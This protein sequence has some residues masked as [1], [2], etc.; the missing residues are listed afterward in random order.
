CIALSSP[1]ILNFGLGD[2]IT[3]LTMAV[4]GGVFPFSF[5]LNAD[6]WKGLSVEQRTALL[7]ANTKGA[8]AISVT[9]MDAADDGLA[10]VTEKGAKFHDASP[11]LVK[12]SQ[13][14]I[15]GDIGTLI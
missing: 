3:D 4:P 8:A 7:R 11:E 10:Y 1:E 15:E 6:T 13:E 12:A 9:Y 2:T 5:Q 14:F